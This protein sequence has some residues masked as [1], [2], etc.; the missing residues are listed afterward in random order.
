LSDSE[1]LPLTQAVL[2][3]VIGVRRNAVSIVAGALQKAAPFA[4]GGR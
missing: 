3:Q 2:A 1:S 4:T